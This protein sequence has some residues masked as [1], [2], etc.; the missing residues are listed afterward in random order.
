MVLSVA[1]FGKPMTWKT[2]FSPSSS[3]SGEKGI[4]NSLSADDIKKGHK[5]AFTYSLYM[6]STHLL[7]ALGVP[8]WTMMFT[9]KTREIR[10]S[11]RE[12][13]VGDLKLHAK[14]FSFHLFHDRHT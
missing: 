4:D 12:L 1:A 13:E 3:N 6:V 7:G 9:K 5:Q 11:F 10:R 2:G 8:A 14:L